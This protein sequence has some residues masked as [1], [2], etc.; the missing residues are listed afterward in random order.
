MEVST[1]NQLRDGWEYVTESFDGCGRA[2]PLSLR[3]DQ[4]LSIVLRSSISRITLFLD[5]TAISRHVTFY[6]SVDPG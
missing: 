6:F 2:T 4:K 3:F 1:N 5:P